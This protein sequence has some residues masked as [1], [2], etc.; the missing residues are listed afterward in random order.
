MADA[1]QG[2]TKALDLIKK[3]STYSVHTDLRR[4]STSHDAVFWRSDQ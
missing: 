4:S 3:K 2:N 1:H